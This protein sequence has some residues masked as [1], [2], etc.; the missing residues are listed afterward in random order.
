MKAVAYY[1]SLPVSNPDS[2]QNIELPEPV[3]GARDLL[4]EVKAIS[5]NPVDTKIRQNVSPENGEAKV[6][7]WDVAGVVKAVGSDV[8]LFQPGDKVYYAGS[9]IRPGANSELHVVDERIVGH[10]PKSLSFAHAA[11]LPLTAI[12]AWELLFERLQIVQ[13]KGESGQSLL[14]VGAAGGV[15]SILTQLARQLTALKVIG[16][17][18]RA[19]TESW[20][21][22]LG[23]HEV[24]DHSKPLSEELK[25][26]GI[27]AV[28]HVASLTQTEQHLDQ[29]V[30]ALKP[31][32][33]LGLIDDPKSLDVSKL[34]RKSLSLHW[35]FMYTRSMFE[36]D[37]IIEQHNLLN[38]VAELVD[39][40]TLKTTFGEHF[41]TINAEN[42]RRAHE[43][44]ESGKAKGKIVLE[45]F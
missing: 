38:R 28:T 44:L 17:A 10:M 14:I 20:V 1:Q 32:G 12:T 9:L 36:T 25:R 2:L 29:L 3:A 31:Q 30:E 43:L 39:A 24:L 40:G 13:G 42:L 6:L 26:V 22:E 34:K 33:K 19:E 7:G 18:S 4:V 41:G 27:Q 16:T 37:D 45:G 5:V 8:T 23:A 21:R 15:G 11:A 35:E